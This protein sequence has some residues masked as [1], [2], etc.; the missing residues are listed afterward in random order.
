MRRMTKGLLWTAGMAAALVAAAPAGAADAEK[1]ANPQPAAA[2]TARPADWAVPVKLNGVPNL[3]RVAPTLYRSAQ[4]TDTGMQNLRKE[5]GIK[6]VINLRAFH[7]DRDE[8]KGTGLLNEELSVNAW[9]I[10]DEDVVRV[11]R[12]L[13]DESKGPFLIHCQHGADRTGVMCAMYRMTVQN[14]PREKAIAELQNGGYGF[15]PI[16]KNII[17]YLEKVDVEKIRRAVKAAP[18]PGDAKAP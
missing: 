5:L 11:L 7:N 18:A 17:R 16:W 3:H 8:S 10:E 9:S 6:T 12:I 14:W 1:A 13:Q 2:A 4:P 15:H